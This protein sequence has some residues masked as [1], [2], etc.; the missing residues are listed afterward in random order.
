MSISNRR[1]WYVASVA[2][3]ALMGLPAVSMAAGA[4]VAAVADSTLVEPVTVVA[5]RS[6]K[7]VDSVPSTVSVITAND[8]EDQLATDIKDLIRYE[9]GVTVRAS[10][11]R[12]GAALGTTGRDGN[13]GFNIRGLEGNRVS[14]LVDG[15]R[16]PDAFSFGA[17]NMGRGDFGDLEL[18]KRV[19]ILRGPG[20]ALYGSDG[21]AGVVSF[22]TKDPSDFLRDG[23]SFGL[24]GRVSYS[25]ADEG[26]SSGLV[27]AFT[28]GDW[29]AMLSYNHR[30]AS[31]TENQGDNSALNS[32]RTAANPQDIDSDA[33]LAKVVFAPSDAHRFRLTYETFDRTVD[34]DVL[35]GRS[36]TVL[37]VVG[38]DTTERDRFG[39]DYHFAGSGDGFVD[40]AVIST[41]WQES[42][43]SQFTFEDRTPAVDRTRLN[44]F[45]NRVYGVAGEFHS[46]FSTGLI[47]H[48]LVYGADSSWTRQEGI[49]D[50]TV[51]PFGETFPTRAFP[52]T[53]SVLAGAYIQDEIG[54][55]GGAVSLFPALR[56]DYYSLD[57]KVDSALPAFVPADQSDSHV[58]PKFGAVWKFA[59][60]WSLFGNYARGFKAPSPSQVNN[61]FT[62]LASAYTSIPNP[63][64]KPETSETLEAGLRWRSDRFAVNGAV[65][66]GQY[67]DFIEQVQVSGSFTSADPAVFQYRNIG[68]VEISGAEVSGQ[69]VLGAGFTASVGASY[70]HGQANSGGVSMPLDSVE[71]V[72]VVAGLSW[73]DQGGRFGGTVNLQH[74]AGKDN[75]RVGAACAPDCFVPGQFTVIDLTGYWNVTDVATVRAGVFNLT[76]QKY[77]FWSD[78][79]G[80]STA[81]MVRDAYTQP[82]RNFGVSLTLRY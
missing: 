79:R 26:V 15:V 2:G 8:I 59:E 23:R 47:E 65:F 69:A 60:G 82:G 14:I 19:E 66:T 31:E 73:R 27:G 9:P 38:H 28:V 81:S 34:T 13:S 12:F 53:N 17:Q 10:P 49:R 25:S 71:P 1:S 30:E 41:Y 52:I 74:G 50:G 75:E 80:L 22:T 78:V 46:S 61:S 64:L 68:S 21:V 44:T 18:I 62:N 54:L 29:S 32:T 39:F 57:P 33:L 77:W 48:N 45:D 55:L 58:S 76:D 16:V 72:K 37:Q 63:D 51:P 3:L 35:S 43:S 67:E 11:A 40:S 36:G 70:A 6:E 56:F 20:S 24:Q 5:T 4:E 42:K 7:Q